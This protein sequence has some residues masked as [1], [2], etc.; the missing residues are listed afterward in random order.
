MNA[1]RR[2]EDVVKGTSKRQRVREK[3]ESIDTIETLPRS[4]KIENST[5]IF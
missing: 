5:Y 1:E 2:V 4:V 3:E